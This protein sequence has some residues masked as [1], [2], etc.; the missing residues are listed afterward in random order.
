VKDLT[1]IGGFA[2]SLGCPVPLFTLSATLHAGVLSA[3]R[4][5]E[6]TGAVCAV[7]ENMAGVTR[8]I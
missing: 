5:A 8:K 7:L 3:G 4:G 6:D 1:V 2:S